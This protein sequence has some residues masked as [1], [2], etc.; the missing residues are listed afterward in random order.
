MAL[1]VKYPRASAGDA[2]DKG[3]VPGSGRC[4]GVGNGSLLR[5]ACLEDSM[6]R[7]ALWAVVHVVTESVVTE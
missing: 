1:V 7:G 3:L 4:P 6:V 2:G 5:Y